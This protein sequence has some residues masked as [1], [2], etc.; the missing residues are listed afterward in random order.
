MAFLAKKRAVVILT[1]AVSGVLARSADS[2][3]SAYVPEQAP[4]TCVLAGKAQAF[5]AYCLSGDGAK[6][7]AK[8]K[9]YFD[10]DYASLPFPAEPLTYGDPDPKNRDSDK[11]DKWRAAQDVCGVIS[12]VAEAGA[13]IGNVTGEEKYFNKAKEF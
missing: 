6:S 4:R 5:K 10:K 11:A 9:A 3:V 13:L 12:G 1:L 2:D 8:I 7:F